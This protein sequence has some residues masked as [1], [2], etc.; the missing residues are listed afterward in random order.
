MS[1]VMRAMG[2]D[3]PLMIAWEA[4]RHTDEYANSLKWAMTADLHMT[5]S[6][7]V[8]RLQHPHTEGSMWAAFM[9][10]WIAAGGKVNP[11]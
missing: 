10:G 8:Q 6:P 2:K 9:A 4:Y 5:A 11:Q 3:E 7:G 1:E